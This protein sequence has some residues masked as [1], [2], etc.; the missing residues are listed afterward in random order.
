MLLDRGLR[1]AEPGGDFLVGQE[2][3]QPQTFFLTRAEPLCHRP[4]R[5]LR[6]S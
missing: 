2:G 5:I 3:G 4:L 1:Q 6:P